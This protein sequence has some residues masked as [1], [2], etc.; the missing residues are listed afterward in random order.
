M[1]PAN[2]ATSPRVISRAH[3]A[4][5]R[6]LLQGLDE[7]ESYRRYL[8]HGDEPVDLR[9][10]RA[11]AQW[12]RD[13]FAAAAHRQARPGTARLVLMD[14]ARF[15][16]SAVLPSLEEFAAARGMEDFSEQEQLE[17]YAEAYPPVAEPRRVPSRGGPSQRPTPRIRLIARQLDALRWLEEQLERQPSRPLPQDRVSAWLN[18]LVA[19]R[20]ER[21][22]LATLTLLT[23]HINATGPRW[24][25]AVPGVGALKARRVVDWLNRHA[26]AASLD[27]LQVAAYAATARKDTTQEVL[28]AVVPA[29][30]ALVPLE[31][32]VVPEVLDGR[33]GRF[34]APVAQ[35]RLAARS[36]HQAIVCWLEAKS[37]TTLTLPLHDPARAQGRA[38]ERAI[39]GLPRL[40]ATARAYRKEAER[41]LLWCVLEQKKPMSSISVDDVLA[42]RAF[43]AAPPPRWCGPRHHQRWSPHWRPLEGP[44]S[45]AAQRHAMTVLSALFGFLCAEGYLTGNPFA[46]AARPLTARPTVESGRVLTLDQWERLQVHLGTL[47]QDVASRRLIRAIRWLY[48]TDL[49]PSELTRARCGDLQRAKAPADGTPASPGWGL[50]VQRRGQ[51]HTVVIPSKLVSALMFELAESGKP[52]DLSAAG[53]ALVPLLAML[54]PG[55]PVKGWSSSG[56]YKAIRAALHRLSCN[57]EDLEAIA[58]RQTGARTLRRTRVAHAR[59]TQQARTLPLSRRPSEARPGDVSAG[60]YPVRAAESEPGIAA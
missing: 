49:R 42:Y 8:Q 18:P 27:A 34:R 1:R 10:V 16:A 31:K 7:R 32:L 24:W 29:A 13:E 19:A 2:S 50:I 4:F 6:A 58:L 40:G 12:L 57:A 46:G 15:D 23:A 22:G 39:K 59:Q 51:D 21:A 44:L 33:D 43:L 60:P 53:T 14:P 41:L 3:F 28:D 36:D 54:A 25:R 52:A 45:V 37:G 17:A 55:Q 30:T 5:M 48:A 11:T 20:L 35:C 38:G 26:T 47:E 56:L 9:T